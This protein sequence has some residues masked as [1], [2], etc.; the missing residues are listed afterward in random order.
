MNAASATARH[1]SYIVNKPADSIGWAV[2]YSIVFHLGIL[3]V[4]YTGLPYVKKQPVVLNTATV[5][6]VQVDEETTANR[7]PQ[8]RSP[9]KMDKAPSPPQKPR[10][11]KMD[12][13]APP[14]LTDP[15]PPKL[16]EDL[17]RP[18]TPSV[19]A[20]DQKPETKP[21]PPPEQKKPDPEESAAAQDNS[22]NALLKNLQPDAPTERVM[23]DPE[24][25]LGLQEQDASPLARFAQQVTMSEMD[26]L[27]A[28][29]NRCWNVPAGA[30]YAE[31]LIVD[32]RIVVNPDR[33]VQSARVLNQR[34]DPAFI[35]A[36]D[37]ALRAINTCSPLNLPPNK[38]DQWKTINFQFDPSKML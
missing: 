1:P 21:K 3:A 31:D 2:A 32:V 19:P 15:K 34:N 38:Y 5:E 26:A 33:T 27:R 23:T 6:I 17:N 7:P 9:P 37:A 30:K 16:A 14:K 28:Q 12:A 29:L 10:T 25:S 8:R 4:M 11:P 24:K 18:V 20:P 22:F 13:K 35:A 36:A